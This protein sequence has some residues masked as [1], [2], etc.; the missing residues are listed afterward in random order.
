MELSY[1]VEKNVKRAW[2]AGNLSLLCLRVSS[3]VHCLYT[4]YAWVEKN[5]FQYRIIPNAYSDIGLLLEYGFYFVYIDLEELWTKIVRK[6]YRRFG[7]HHVSSRLRGVCTG[8]QRNTPFSLAVNCVEACYI[9]YLDLNI[10]LMR[11]TFIPIAFKMPYLFI[12]SF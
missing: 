7:V 8:F 9:Q 1:I 5:N 4:F 11:A 2:H 10:G 6:A 12:D 3:C